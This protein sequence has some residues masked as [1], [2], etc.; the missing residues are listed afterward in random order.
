VRGQAIPP[1]GCPGSALSLE[2]TCC[3]QAEW[4]KKT[5]PEDLK[6]LCHPNRELDRETNCKTLLKEKK[7]KVRGRITRENVL[8][9]ARW[10]GTE[11]W[12]SLF[13][14]NLNVKL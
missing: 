12:I 11:A 7:E 2:Q 5:S 13:K 6:F 4:S 9:P 8:N 1:P 10:G 3:Y 14:F